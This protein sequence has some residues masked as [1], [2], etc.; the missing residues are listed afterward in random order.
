MT[1]TQLAGRIGVDQSRIP[2]LERAEAEG[3]ITLKTLRH[4]AEG[5]DCTVVYALVPN[6]PL[7]EILRVRAGEVADHR[8]ARAHHTMKL[9]NQ[10][11]GAK[12]LNA[13]RERLIDALMAGNPRRLWDSA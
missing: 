9:E 1:T 13:E 3:S 12:D 11:L 7:D 4:V 10:A 5:L 6:Q 2:R 8:V